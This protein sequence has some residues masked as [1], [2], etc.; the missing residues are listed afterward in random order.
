M[1]CSI[2]FIWALWRQRMNYHHAKEKFWIHRRGRWRWSVCFCRVQSW[3][4]IDVERASSPTQKETLHKHS[5]W[6]KTEGRGKKAQRMEKAEIKHQSWSNGRKRRGKA[7]ARAWRKKDET[8]QNLWLPGLESEWEGFWVG[9]VLP[10]D[11]YVSQQQCWNERGC[12]I[13][14]ENGLPVDNSF[15]MK[16]L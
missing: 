9:A 1:E 11:F 5:K 16:K 7:H 13:N 6:L 3:V 14:P 15:G 12:G 8:R 10:G 2:V 4:F